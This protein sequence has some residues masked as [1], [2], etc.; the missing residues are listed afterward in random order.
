MSM[1]LF[2]LRIESIDHLA[3]AGSCTTKLIS[4]YRVYVDLFMAVTM[5]QRIQARPLI[6]ISY[7]NRKSIDKKSTNLKI[8]AVY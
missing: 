7:L 1:Y 8:Y 6:L 3:Y 5:T 4:I 2:H